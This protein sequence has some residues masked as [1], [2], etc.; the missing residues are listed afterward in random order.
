MATPI[1][2][3]QIRQEELATAQKQSAQAGQKT[4]D[5]T[6]I[7]DAT[8]E[9]Q[10]PK[11]TG[12]LPSLIFTLGS[13][14][15]QIIQPS[16][17]NLIQ[18]YIPNPDVCP[19]E[20]TLNELISQRNNIVVSLNNI[21]NRVDQLGNSITGTSNFLN[22]TL[23]IITAVETASIIVSA[24][25]RF[26][27]TIPGAVVS[28]LNDA[29]TFIRKT[30]FDRLGNSR[31]SKIQGV[32]SSSALVIS[33][34]GTYILTVKSLLVIIDSYI[35]KCQIN[36]NIV[37][38]SNIVDSIA[39]AQLQAQQ[40]SNQ[41]TYNGFIIEIEEIPFT[42]TV[43]RRRAVGKNQSGIVLTQTELSFTTNPQ[44]LINEL[45]FIIDR[46]NLKAY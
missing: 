44:T 14:I 42:P 31:L 9:D 35:N 21:G 46:D 23:G 13:Q 45:K 25:A 30:T 5:D 4:V 3:E 10:K 32:I 38:I 6:L 39:N 37:P 16:L 18:T 12:K 33:I 22:V 40:T 20:S 24:A 19:T 34:V 41:V 15:P 36:P 11:G 26:V 2:L 1:E 17:Q 43:I 7:A 27:P 29:Q 8:P 28:A